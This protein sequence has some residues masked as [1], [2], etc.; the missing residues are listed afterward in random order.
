MN[1]KTTLPKSLHLYLSQIGTK[2]G[3]A[4]KGKHHPDPAKMRAAVMARIKKYGER[5][6]KTADYT[7]KDG[8][9]VIERK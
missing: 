3:L 4:G 8:K 6:R 9:A 7:I 5:R 2:G 1:T